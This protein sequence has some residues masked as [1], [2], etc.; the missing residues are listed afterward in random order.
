MEGLIFMSKLKQIAEAA[1]RSAHDLGIVLHT[2]SANP[3]GWKETKA[4]NVSAQTYRDT[5]TGSYVFG[6]ASGS[7]DIFDFKTLCQKLLT[8]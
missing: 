3:V 7:T 8:I 1:L 5:D 6:K 4:K 2:E